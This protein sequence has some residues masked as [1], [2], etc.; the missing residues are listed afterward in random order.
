[1]WEASA[2]HCEQGGSASFKLRRWCDLTFDLPVSA[3]LAAGVPGHGPGHDPGCLLRSDPPT[4]PRQA[5]EA[6]ALAHLLLRGRIRPHT[7]HPLD[8]HHR[9]LLLRARAGECCHNNHT[10]H[11][12]ALIMC[13]VVSFSFSS[14]HHQFI[15]SLQAFVPRVLGMYFIAAL[16]L[17]F[18][19]SKVPERYFP[20]E[21]TF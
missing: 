16:A 9:R 3:V 2:C 6:A 1:M 15:S 18:Y 4:L 13:R 17:I 20:G 11:F 12:T 8:L 14:T 19:V 7:H 21:N 10:F 5:V